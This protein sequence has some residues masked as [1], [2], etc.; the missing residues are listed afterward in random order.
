VALRDGFCVAGS[1]DDRHL[2]TLA[3]P[4]AAITDGVAAVVA[5]LTPTAPPPCVVWR[6]GASLGPGPQ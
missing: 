6:D 5:G 2:A 4:F 3:Y 1:T